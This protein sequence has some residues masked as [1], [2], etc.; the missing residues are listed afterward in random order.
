MPDNLSPRLH[1]RHVVAGSAALATALSL[2]T[3]LAQ[4]TPT[5]SPVAAFDWSSIEPMM[6]AGAPNS[7]LLVTEIAGPGE[8]QPVFSIDPD[9]VLPIG[10]N[11]KFWIL[12]TLT[13]QVADG[14]LTWEQPVELAEEHRS[15]PGGDLRYALPGTTYTLRYVAERM[16]QK[17]DNTATD[18]LLALAGRE[19]VEAMMSQ[20]VTNPDPNLPLIST[21][22]LAML[23]F[24]YPT[25]KLDAYYAASVE[26]RRQILTD[27]I[28]TIP[29]EALADIDQTAPLEIDRVEWFASRSDLAR[30]VEWIYQASKAEELMPAREVIALE[31]QLTFDAQIWPYVGFK[32]GSEM[33]VLSGTWLMQR[34]DDRWFIYSIGF[35]NEA[36]EIDMPAAIT[37]MEAIRDAMV[38]IP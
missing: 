27:E 1:R 17:S 21:R 35:M 5:A 38:T 14:T 10:S 28:N 31:T 16:M 36:G 32:G 19:N 9:L 20:F 26:E 34:H 13:Q 33:G 15:V 8:L 30:V 23:K 7:A 3:S 29:Y 12:A 24:A 37:A 6:A 2:R 22:E 11:F 25:D 4:G 18:N